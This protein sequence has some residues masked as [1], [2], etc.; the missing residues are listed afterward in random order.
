MSI[1][2]TGTVVTGDRRG[3]ELGFPTANVELD[4]DSTDPPADGVYAGWFE[5]S[6]GAR[7]TA[8]ISIG[9]RPT[10]YGV[11]GVRLVEAHL[12]DYEGDLYGQHVRVGVGAA[13]RPQERFSDSEQLVA[14]MHDDVRRVRELSATP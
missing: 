1:V 8:A 7:H 2:L 6:G 9:G 13:V 5:D 12:L 4:P 3:R 10:Y 14:Q 11:D